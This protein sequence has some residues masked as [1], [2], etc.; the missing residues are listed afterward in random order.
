MR[1]HI[2]ILLST[3][4]LLTACGQVK[5]NT[6]SEGV[7]AEEA[8]PEM[9]AEQGAVD[10]AASKIQREAEAAVAPNTDLI[11]EPASK[12][13]VT[14]IKAEEI[15]KGTTDK[16]KDDKALAGTA[17]MPKFEYSHSYSFAATANTLG[18]MQ[19]KHVAACEAMGADRCKVANFTQDLNGSFGATGTLQ[20]YVVTDRAN[21]LI[22]KFSEIAR[23]LG[24]ERT[25]TEMLGNNV[26]SQAKQ[27][28]LNVKNALEEKAR[29]EAILKSSGSTVAE[30]RGAAEALAELNPRLNGEKMDLDQ[31][32]SDM[33]YSKM[34][35]S[36]ESGM[37]VTTMGWIALLL[38]AMGGGL[39]WL[40]RTANGQ[41]NKRQIS[42]A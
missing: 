29:L 40:S 39:F 8:A 10:M 21:G 23:S 16:G 27:A 1:K 42:A 28:E 13:P 14:S 33:G 37:P 41:A 35:I 4:F 20:L 2:A 17:R 30:K 5:E 6:A 19:D 25:K 3:T 36:Y 38:L 26:T 11:E 34:D 9:K 18:E 32:A 31:V 12:K 24:G 15:A 7:A 22:S